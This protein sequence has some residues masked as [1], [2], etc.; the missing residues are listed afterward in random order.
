[1]LPRARA[2]GRRKLG[3]CV[4][5]ASPIAG[6]EGEQAA[7]HH[8]LAASRVSPHPRREE[9]A[10]WYRPSARPDLGSPN[11][12]IIGAQKS[13][14]SWLARQLDQHPDVFVHRGE[15]HFFDKRHNLCK[16]REWYESH[17][18][19]ATTQR[20][21]GEKPPDYLWANGIGAE[22]HL[23]DVH[24]NLHA[25]YP[26]AKLIVVLRNPVDRAISAV[27][28]LIRSGRISP[29]LSVDALLVGNKRHLVEQHGV[30]QK[31]CYFE[32]VSA[33]LE[34][35]PRERM[36]FLIFEEDVVHRPGHSL[37]A[38]C[39]FLGVSRNFE[40]T[41]LNA[42]VNEFNRSILSL[43]VSYYMPW[44]DRLARRLDPHLAHNKKKPSPDTLAGMYDLFEEENEKLFG[45]LGRCPPSWIRE[46]RPQPGHSRPEAPIPNG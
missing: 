1:M 33:Y 41:N 9:T 27:N 15:I 10:L 26:D 8:C 14:S 43:A 4:R 46:G 36:L 28:N 40:F 35:F 44:A 17:F 7:S 37:A 5:H 32:Q 16:G 29:L 12:F 34:L 30:I 42:R 24:R 39:D 31:G 19:A 3:G 21:I 18:A 6:P 20:A 38:V 45:L 13:G 25:F 22:G 2:R 11:F 23:P